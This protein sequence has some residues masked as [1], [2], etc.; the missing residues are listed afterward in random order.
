LH[1]TVN[2]ADPVEAKFDAAVNVVRS[3][4][5][6]G[7]YQPSYDTMLKVKR[8]RREDLAVNLQG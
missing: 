5:K 2:M 1:L 8:E 6:K 7:A 4:P 3:M